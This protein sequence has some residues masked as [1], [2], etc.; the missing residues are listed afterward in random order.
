MPTEAE[1]TALNFTILGIEGLIRHAEQSLA[2]ID[3]LDR[4][5]GDLGREARAR[6][7]VMF[8]HQRDVALQAKSLRQASGG[9]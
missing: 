2:E 8:Q 7:R 5:M 4:V 3:R 9:L 6:G 1:Q